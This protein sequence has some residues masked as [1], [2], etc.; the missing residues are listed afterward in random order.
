MP[1]ARTPRAR[2]RTHIHTRVHTYARLGAAPP[3]RSTSLPLRASRHRSERSQLVI[4]M[5]GLPGRGKTFLLS[6][7]DHHGGPARPRKDVPVSFSG[8]EHEVLAR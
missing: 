4:I 7:G 5:V 3:G 2:I 6:A 8:V 1:R